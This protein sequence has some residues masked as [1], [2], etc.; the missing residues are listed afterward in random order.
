MMN[1]EAPPPYKRL[2]NSNGLAISSK[3]EQIK[4][5]RDSKRKSRWEQR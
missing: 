4:H 5:S 1:F 3:E 2:K